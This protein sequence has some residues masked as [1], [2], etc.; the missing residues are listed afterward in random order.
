[1]KLT[2]IIS[3]MALAG[4]MTMGFLTASAE[5]PIITFHTNVYDNTGET[6][7]FHFYLGAKEPIYVDVDCGFGSIETE[8]GEAV[9]DSETGGIS[10]TV[11]TCTVS[12][13]GMVRIYGDASKIDY[14]DMEGCY[15][16]DIS[17]PQLTE[18]E[19]INL[20]YNELNA[21]DLSHMT[22]LQSIDVSRNPFTA[23]TPL[24]I[25]ANKPDLAI[26]DISIIDY[27]DQ[28]F[29]LSDY[30]AMRSFLAWSVRDL[31]TIDP[32]GCPYLL[33]LSADLSG[34]SSID[35]SKNPSLMILNV[36][37]TKV[38][39]L[40]LSNNPYLTELYCGHRAAG[41]E[42]YKMT[43]LDL[44]NKSELQRLFCEGNALTTLDVSG[45]PKLINL[46]CTNNLLTEL[47]IDACPNI[48]TLNVMNNLMDFSTLPL[49]RETFNEYYYTQCPIA[50]ARSYAVGTKLDFS[51][52]VLREGSVTQAFLFQVSEESPNTPEMLPEDYYSYENGTFTLLKTVTDS[53]YVT[54]INDIFQD[55][56]MTTSKFLVKEESEMGKPN[57]VIDLSFYPTVKQVSLS[58]GLQGAT[59]ENPKTFK[60]DFGNGE[61]VDFTATTNELPLAP[62]VT[63]TRTGHVI[64]YMPEDSDIS[65]FAI[66]GQRLM[67]VDLTRAI[68][69]AH[70]SITD[71]QLPTINLAWNRC[72]RSLDLSGNKL[73]TLDLSEPNGSYGKNVL[74]HINASNNALTEVE[75]STRTA[76]L[77]LDL[78]DNNIAEM[79]LTKLSSLTELNLSGNQLTEVSLTDLEAIETLNLSGNQLTSIQLLD[80]LPLQNFDISSN[81]FTFAT[82][83][84]PGVVAEYK[85]A[86][87]NAILLPAMA[88][89]A[90]LSECYADID[91][92]TTSYRWVMDAT[93]ADVPAGS[94]TTA[95][96]GRFRFT[97]ADLGVV[98]CEMTHP[99]FPDFKG[100]DVLSTTAV[101][102]AEMPTHVFATFTTTETAEA[103]LVLAAQ[104]DGAAVYI[105]WEGTGD[106]EQYSL[107][108]SYIS[109]AVNTH[110]GAEVKCY[111]YD[112]NDAVTVFSAS[113]IKMSKIDASPMK[114]LINFSLINAGLENGSIVYPSCMNTLEELSLAGNNLSKLDFTEAP[115]LVMLNLNSNAFKTFDASAFKA[116]TNLY[117]AYNELESVKL[118]NPVMWECAL[119][120]NAL[121]S[122]DLS[123]VPAMRQ[124][125]LSYNSL[126]TIDISAITKLESFYIDRNNFTFA[127]LPL[128]SDITTYVYSNQTPLV[129]TPTDGYIVDLSSQKECHGVPTTYTWYI[130]SP[131]YDENDNLVG[132]N[133]Y[134]GE[135]YT[136][137][138]GVTTFIKPFTHIMC[139]MTNTAL[140]DLLL[141]TDFIDVTPLQDSIE[142]VIASDSQAARWYN[143]SGVCVAET[144]EGQAPSL[145]PGIYVRVTA[146]SATKVLVD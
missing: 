66:N 136:I 98:R 33:Q 32:T 16:S 7:A 60:V 9:F 111:S 52:K 58:V 119:V 67:S 6:N 30:P 25:G 4:A 11:I 77:S 118:D 1:M 51:D 109:F 19:I 44:S 137:K 36:A 135:E 65:A 139:V 12:E 74:S 5:E 21:L 97:D 110:A 40:D 50:M 93:G 64:I 131:Y 126:S 68:T 15:I 37:D 14:I 62:N 75:L 59:S 81:N 117:V 132:E 27:I 46:S 80:Y 61:L 92:Q 91:G 78:S 72:L 42:N 76:I 24:V 99:V 104:K 94:I 29:N 31:K 141:Y 134:E 54:F 22:K 86:P 10:A 114:S 63:G 34:I 23:E 115:A 145:A 3:R 124:L 140:P 127:T 96:T 106:V 84:L 73:S 79:S 138:D 143:L 87:Q 56:P 55:Y 57:P 120:N 101:Q 71:C 102:T 116:L 26:L 108:T 49:P 121:E 122:I 17:F 123:K 8:V 112:E 82:L 83:P 90:N 89:T 130:D 128:G 100:A 70:L 47:N 95:G 133:L 45:C 88:P 129:V 53:V 69:L 48:A 41:F 142:E 146:S 38:T 39:E 113:D 35:V 18:V 144:A 13:E 2:S 105:D 85:Y 20:S 28:S 103:T 107:Q 125:F 43:S